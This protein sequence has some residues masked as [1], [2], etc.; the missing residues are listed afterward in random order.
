LVETEL[1]AEIMMAGM[2]MA[3]KECLA[4]RKLAGRETVAER[5]TVAGREK[6]SSVLNGWLGCIYAS[7]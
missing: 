3:G 5:E 2:D 6:N 4:S 7:W 1:I